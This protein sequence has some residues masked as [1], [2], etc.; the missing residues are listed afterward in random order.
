MAIFEGAGVAIVTPFL[1][2]GDVN[3]GKL[4]EYIDFQIEN[5][6]DAIIICGTTGEASTMT[7]DEHLEPTAPPLTGR[8]TAMP[9]RICSMN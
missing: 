6:T 9:S 8:R 7:D 1:A 4:E 5:D 2:N 3:F